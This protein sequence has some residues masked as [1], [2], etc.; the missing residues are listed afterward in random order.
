MIKL[1]KGWAILTILTEDFCSDVSFG[2]ILSVCRFTCL[3]SQLACDLSFFLLSDSLIN[4]VTQHTLAN[5]YYN[6]DPG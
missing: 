4:N 2:F 3:F 1:S 5:S 6:I